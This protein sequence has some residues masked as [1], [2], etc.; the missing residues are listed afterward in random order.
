MHTHTLHIYQRPAIGNTFVAR[1]PVY[2]Y[3]HKITAMGGFDT[4]SCKLQTRS[5]REAEMFLESHVGGRVAAYADNPQEPIWE[6]LINRITLNTGAGAY[7]ISMDE[8]VNKCDTMFSAPGSTT[9]LLYGTSSNTTSQA[10]FGIKEGKFDLG[11][12]NNTSNDLRFDI[13]D[14]LLIERAWPKTSWTETSGVNNTIELECIGFYH[15]LMWEIYANTATTISNYAAFITTNLLG[16]VA[17]GTTFFDNTDTS[18]IET[19]ASV[20]RVNEYGSRPIWEI[21]TMQCDAG[22][23]TGKWVAGITPTRSDGTRALYYRPFNTDLAYTARVSEQLLLRDIYNRRVRPWTAQPDR[24]I[25]VSD[26]L[27]GWSLVGDDPRETWI[28]S[29]EYDAEQQRVTWAGADDTTTEGAFQL[30]RVNKTTNSRFGSVRR[31]IG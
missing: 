19:N 12:G 31:L 1:Y 30:R 21:L 4:M 11:V 2:Q 20:R 23:G 28:A 24:A 8:M 25:K 18:L 10:V 3:K 15:T 7:T 16:A 13:R 6:G 17:N 9:P 5:R 26:V 29:I 22:D 14:A 27:I